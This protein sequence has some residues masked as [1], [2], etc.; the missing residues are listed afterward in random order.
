MSKR[1]STE[2]ASKKALDPFSFFRDE[3]RRFFPEGFGPAWEQGLSRSAGLTPSLD[4]KEKDGG[5]EIAVELP[6]VSEKDVEVSV[7]NHLL[8]I[9]GEKRE[10]KDEKSDKGYHVMERRYGSFTRS[11]SLPDDVDEAKIDA[12]VSDGVLKVVLPRSKATKDA[13]KKIA[14]KS[15]K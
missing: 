8:T 2:I 6:G 10:E 12:S 13:R 5:Y 3:M 1:V 11:I 14:I 4:I 9:S 15:A 7:A